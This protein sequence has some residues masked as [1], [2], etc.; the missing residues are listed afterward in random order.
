VEV[1]PGAMV[2]GDTEGIGMFTTNVVADVVP[3]VTVTVVELFVLV[4]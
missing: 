4:A 1:E 3:E 2:V